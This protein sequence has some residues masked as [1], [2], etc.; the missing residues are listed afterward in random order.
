[1]KSPY[2]IVGDAHLGFKAYGSDRRTQEVSDTFRTAVELL[3]DMP[4]IFFPGDL[5]DETTCSNRVKRDLLALKEEHSQQIWVIDGGNHDSTK[6]YSSV[7]VLD[8]FSEVHNVVAVNNFKAETITVAGLK[9]LLIPHTRSQND[10]LEVLDNLDG[11]WDLALLHC[12]V[13][14]ELDLG[15]NDLNLDRERM[16]RLASQCGRVWIGHQHGVR[17][18][19]NNV[20]IPGGTVEFNFGELGEKFVYKVTDKV[21]AIP[22]PQTRPLVQ[23]EI[24]WKGPIELLQT[25]LKKDTIYKLH[26]VDV[27]AEDYSTCKSAMD[28]LV[29]Q[30]DGDVLYVIDKVGEAAVQV[31]EI[32][33]SF[34]LLGEFREFGK[35]LDADTEAMEILLE[36]AISE[37]LAEEE[38]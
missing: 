25:E 11:T 27:P 12:M 14:S 20:Y 34:D 37:L 6:T 19:L 29:A 38:K 16:K 18:P 8:S 21:T 5:F 33:A 9:V 26:V 7:S 2:G 36:D 4:V 15:P 23:L 1:M 24:T 30:Y 28:A 22:I 13:Q 35:E 17:Q 32:N 10:F 31:T 3:S